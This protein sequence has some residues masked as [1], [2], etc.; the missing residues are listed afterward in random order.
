[1]RRTAL[2][3]ALAAGVVFA[4]AGPAFAQNAPGTVRDVPNTN[5]VVVFSNELLP[6]EA[7]QDPHGCHRLPTLSHVLNNETSR[8]VHLH[9]DAY[10]MTPDVPILPGHG[11]HTTQLSGSFSS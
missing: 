5:Q 8:T 10:C 1:M 4:G 3:A 7:Y 11:M 2:T 6:L 9:A